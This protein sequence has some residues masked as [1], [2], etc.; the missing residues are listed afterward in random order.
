MPRNLDLTALR[1]LVAVADAGGV[2]RAAGALNL[3]QSAV[4]MQLKRLEES[5]GVLLLD[6]S[7]RG[8]APT[9]AG[10]QLLSYARRMLALNDE[11]WARLTAREDVGVVSLGVPADLIYPAIPQVLR[12]FARDFPRIKVN[13]VSSYTRTLK[14]AFARG[15]I[16]AILTTEDRPD[17]AAETLAVRPLV[18]VGAPDATAWT[19]RPLRLAFSE[20]CIFRQPTQRRLDAA[21]I[22]W[23]MAVETSSDRTADATVS[24]DLAVS[25][26]IDDGEF[27]RLAPIGHRGALPDL[28][29]VH[30]N[31]YARTEGGAA[32]E[33]MVELLRREYQRMLPRERQ[34]HATPA[35]VAA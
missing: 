31:L 8:V 35:I 12:R 28:W 2:T 23:E 18:W 24:A 32:Q 16:D 34:S 11:A 14:A 19:Q 27:T 26:A 17:A 29:R 21:G 4:S 33:G 20:N 25:V 30:V 5:I 15:E 13:L 6:R 7:G 3:T 1:S 9:P 22:P 10:E